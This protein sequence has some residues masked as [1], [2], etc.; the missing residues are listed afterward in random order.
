MKTA[1]HYHS[2]YSKIARSFL[3]GRRGKIVYLM[4]DHDYRIAY[5]CNELEVNGTLTANGISF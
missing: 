5:F 2:S 3:E 4:V 1:I